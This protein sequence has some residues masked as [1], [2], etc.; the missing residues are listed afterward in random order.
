VASTGKP[1]GGRA[2]YVN[3]FTIV[4]LFILLIA[5]INFMNLTTARSV[6]RAKEVG[7]RKTV[8]ALRSKLIIKFLSEAV[9]LCILSAILSLF[10]VKLA[11][12]AFNDLTGKQLV[13][14]IAQPSFWWKIIILVLITGLVSGSYPAL[15]LSS[16]NPVRVLKGSIKFSLSALWFRKG[17]AIF[18]FVISI[19]LIIGAIVIARQVNY[20]QAKDLGFNKENLVYIPF[21]GDLGSKYE[22]FKQE[23]LQMP[24]IKSITY[25]GMMSRLDNG[26]AFDTYWTGKNPNNKLSFNT[27]S[28]GYDFIITGGLTLI[29]GRDFARDFPS[30]TTGYIIN[31]KALSVIGYKDPIGQPLTVDGHKGKIIG[32]VRDFNFSSLHNPIRPLIITFTNDVWGYALIHAQPGKTKQAIASMEKVYKQLNPEYAFTFQFSDEEYGRLYQNEQIVGKLSDGFAFL[33]III[34]CLGLLGLAM[35]TVEQRTKEI[36]IRKVLGASAAKIVVMLSKD[37]LK[38]VIVSAVIATPFAFL[39]MNKWIQQFA[40]RIHIS[41]WLFVGAGLFA[42]FISLSTIS[43]QA[44][45]A[46]VANPMKSLKTE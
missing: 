29:K 20:I 12:P 7:I 4:A 8:G 44:I 3:I 36:G 17:L 42:L 1:S 43:F 22:V 15:F 11:L 26:W 45:R 33:A 46:A 6:K 30:D 37:I 24:G 23:L 32:L 39:A 10:L 40:Y 34:S 19:V 2:E 38:L 41:A 5:C 28:V 16:L 14:P 13:L 27:E 35:F 18:Q 9:L 25:T 31:E 21:E